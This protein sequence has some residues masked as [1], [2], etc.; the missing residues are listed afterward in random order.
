MMQEHRC[1]RVVE[2]AVAEGQGEDVG[3][4]D[5]EARVGDVLASVLR[6]GCMSIDA[7]D[8]NIE[9][10]S[11]GPLKYYFRDVGGPGGEVDHADLFA[12]FPGAT[13]A[14]EVC[15]CRARVTEHAVDFSDEPEAMEKLIWID[16]GRVHPL[17]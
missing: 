15:E 5:A 7:D 16:V 3:L 1:Q 4:D 14:I 2:F 6:G 10:A 9:T 13:E 11:V 17:G 8:L 12:G